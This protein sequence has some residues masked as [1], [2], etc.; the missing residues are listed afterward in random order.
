MIVHV[1]EIVL[2]VCAQF[3]LG[4]SF[5]SFLSFLAFSVFLTPEAAFVAPFLRT[6]L[7]SWLSSSRSCAR[8][9]L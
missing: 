7:L 6:S 8:S 1:R 5:L 2:E 9:S 4:L 3:F